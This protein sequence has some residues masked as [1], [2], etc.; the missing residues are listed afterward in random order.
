MREKKE[1]NQGVIQTKCYEKEIPAREKKE[2]TKEQYQRNA[3]RRSEIPAREKKEINQR[4]IQ[5]VLMR[6][7]Q[8]PAREKKEINQGVI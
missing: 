2:V 7:S 5:N 8:I 1:I 4:V 6:R 3:V